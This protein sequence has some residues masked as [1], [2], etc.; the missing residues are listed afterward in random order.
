[1]IRN[2]KGAANLMSYFLYV[3]ISLI[4]LGTIVYMV[5]GTI[6]QNEEKYNFDE[7]V[8]NIDLI[9]NT[10][11]LVSSSRFSAREVTIYNPDVIEID[12]N[13]N[14]IKGEIEYSQ[15]LKNEF[16]INDINISFV[17]NRLYFTKS[18]NTSDANIDCNLTSLNKGKINYIFKYEDYNFETNKI[19]ISINLLDFNKSTT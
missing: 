15:N 7:M 2:K 19:N 16:N 17:S 11:D 14:L 5:Q 6:K 4:V 12:C 1:M 8:N 3:F 13:N 10:F 18:I 9:S